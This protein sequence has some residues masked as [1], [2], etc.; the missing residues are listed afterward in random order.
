MNRLNF[1][2]HAPFALLISSL[3][4]IGGSTEALGAT[5]GTPEPVRRLE[6]V[7]RAI[8]FHGG[9]LYT[10]RATRLDLCSKSGCFQV[11]AA[12][13]G[14]RFDYRVRRET[15]ETR[16]EVRSTNETLEVWRDGVQVEIEAARAQ[17]YR[18]WAMARVYFCF[19]P[20][21]LNDPSV[22]KQDL[23]L[24]EWQGRKLHKVKVT[25]DAGSSTDAS[26][27]YVYWFDPESA[28]LEYFAYS[29]DDNGGGLRFRRAVNHRRVGGI[30]FFDQENLG[31]EDAE[32]SV[33]ALDAEVVH[34]RLR[35]ISTVRLENIRVEPVSQATAAQATAD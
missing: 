31:S 13:D 17:G 15:E 29:Y 25:F 26:D 22:L 33:D 12:M 6:I 30:L 32:L 8:A 27:E 10:S 21:R 20:F 11:D 19:L 1:G 16:L 3:M 24:V 34:D 14:D 35:Q 28:R 2:T 7:D 23:G 9:D 5:E 4:A 18:D